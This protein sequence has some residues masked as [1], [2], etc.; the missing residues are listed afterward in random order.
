MPDSRF[1]DF[2]R[3]NFLASATGFAAALPILGAAAG[4]I[5][6]H[7]AD[8][9]GYKALVCILLQ[10]GLD[11]ADMIFPTDTAEFERLRALRPGIIASHGADRDPANMSTINA[12]IGSRRFALPGEMSGVADLFNRGDAAVVANVGPLVEPTTREDLDRNRAVLPKR[13][14]SHN[15]Q[16]SVWLSGESEGSSTGWGGRIS[17]RVSNNGSVFTACSVSDANIFLTGAATRGL[18]L[19]VGEL[20]DAQV[21]RYDYLLGTGRRNARLRALLDAHHRAEGPRG[22]N[23][24]LRDVADVNTRAVDSMET[25]ADALATSSGSSVAFPRN[26]LGGQLKQIADTIAISGALGVGRQVFYA[27]LGGFDTH[28]SQA[29]DLPNLLAEV[30]DAITAFQS[31]MTAMGRADEVT[32]FTAS[33]FGRTLTENGDGTDHGWGGH[34]LVVGGAVRGGRIIGDLPSYDLDQ[35]TYTRDRGRLIPGL[36]VDQYGATLA[37]W[38]GLTDSEIDGVFPRLRN[39]DTRDIGLFA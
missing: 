10:G 11:G 18:V 35:P 38:F 32:L 33:D 1:A 14:F 29:S 6:A 37:R 30:S 20:Q 16:Q 27:S 2:S 24:I 39:F 31:A 3:R 25:Y 34:H 21:L 8:N 22:E 19:P 15:D 12:S 17:D 13:L 9:S 4:G 23:I 5:N 26:R 28:S 36:S 7:A